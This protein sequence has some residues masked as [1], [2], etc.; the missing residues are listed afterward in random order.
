MPS[1][2]QDQWEN[3]LDQGYIDYS[4]WVPEHYQVGVA[5]NYGL[6]GEGNPFFQGI[7]A[8]GG[9]DARW[10]V[11]SEQD[12]LDYLSF[13]NELATH[14]KKRL[15][16]LGVE[17][18]TGQDIADFFII[19]GE[20]QRVEGAK[21]QTLGDIERSGAL[22]SSEA[23]RMGASVY[24]GSPALQR[25]Q[26][27]TAAAYAKPS[28]EGLLTSAALEMA[29]GIEGGP[30]LAP[31]Q[32]LLAAAELGGVSHIGAQKTM[33]EAALAPLAIGASGIG[34]G[35]TGAMIGGGI[36]A[37]AALPFVIGGAHQAGLAQEAMS[38]KMAALNPARVVMPSWSSRIKST[39]PSGQ[40]ARPY[41]ANQAA[42][43][44]IYGDAG[45]GSGSG[46]IFG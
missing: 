2:A 16:R 25:S 37:G 14:N 45:R 40:T 11:E 44:G 31:L 10:N 28:N 46:P 6:T 35:N 12:I 21:A 1:R 20:K 9:R 3:W 13:A 18:Y 5:E 34:S 24:G 41:G 23:G 32:D 27:G 8:P 39:R 42:L 29:K 36:T 7:S 38:K 33:S 22:A 19:P 30:R 15:G 17:D 26:E 43:A 4:G